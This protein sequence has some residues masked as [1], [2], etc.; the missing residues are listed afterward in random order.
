MVRNFA[1]S[2]LEKLKKLGMAA[3]R[4]RDIEFVP[5]AVFEQK[6][7][8]TELE[9][10]EL[11]TRFEAGKALWGDLPPPPASIH[12]VPGP[13]DLSRPPP[14]PSASMLLSGRCRRELS[15]PFGEGDDDRLRAIMSRYP[16][17]LR[18]ADRQAIAAEFGGGK[19]VRQL[20]HRWESYAKPGL[21]NGQF[22][23]SERRQVA[24]LAIDQPGKWK[25][26]AAQ[27]GNGRC[28]SRVML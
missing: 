7:M 26:I 4:G 9:R 19:T 13:V 12:R 24:A 27:L 21:D 23:L 14:P 10:R 20:Q 2:F 6:K 16:E 11:V 25:W 5:D 17:R 1:L 28:R 8:P 18:R 3:E 22:T 15:G